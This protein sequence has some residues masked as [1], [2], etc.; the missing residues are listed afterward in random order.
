[1]S[2]VESVAKSRPLTGLIPASFLR[3]VREGRHTTK[4]RNRFSRSVLVTVP[5]LL[6]GSLAMSLAVASP[7][8]AAPAKKSTKQKAPAVAKAAKPAAQKTAAAPATYKVK[9]G[10]TVSSVATQYGLST[11][12]VLTLNGLGWK[13]LI[14]PGQVLKLNK[15]A[16]SNAIPVSSVAPTTKY[17]ILAGDTVGDVAKKF[18]VSTNAVLVANGLKT[19]SLIFPGQKIAVPDA[20]S[21]S[22][23]DIDTVAIELVSNITPSATTY[24]IATGDTIT[25]VAAK[26]GVSVEGILAAND[27]NGSSIIYAGRSITVP[28]ASTYVSGYGTVTT[29][30]AEMRTNAK[31]IIGVGRSLGASN[32]ALVIALATAMQESGLKNI[33]YG[34]LDSVG[35]FQQR[36]SQGWGTVEQILSP[37]YAARAF[38]LGVGDNNP[39]LFDIAGWSLM[40]VT[41]AAQSV[42][43]SAFPNAY[44]QWQGSAEYWLSELS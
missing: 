32:R 33:S 7:A 2:N 28:K 17:T 14:Y 1:M 29:L 43:V 13:S 24:V 10:D 40:S 27:L 19:T 20:G 39:G 25:S 31:T 9:D 37:Q 23:T 21:F 30:T 41:K 34:D 38:F 4:P 18:G 5:I 3:P 26:F 11:A 42:Q 36:P 12:S 35:L 16:A 6:I 8:D 15:A 44:A 22:S